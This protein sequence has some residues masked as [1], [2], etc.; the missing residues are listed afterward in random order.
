MLEFVD[1]LG[2]SEVCRA[3]DKE[4]NDSTMLDKTIL[5]KRR[6]SCIYTTQEYFES[7]HVK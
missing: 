1:D 7:K 2:C 6:S 4:L 5:T 3:L